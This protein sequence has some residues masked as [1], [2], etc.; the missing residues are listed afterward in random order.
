MASCRPQ[1]TSVTRGAHLG[2][3]SY[4]SRAHLVP[5]SGP[6]RTHLGPIS[7]PSRALAVQ[8]RGNDP[9]RSMGSGERFC[10]LTFTEA[11][12]PVRDGD[13][14]EKGDRRVKPRNRRQPGR[15]RL[16]WTAA[17]TTGCYGSVHP[18]LRS[19][20]STTQLPSQLL[21]RTES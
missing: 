5:I 7:C 14:W 15:P 12:R 2:P 20:H 17:R 10:C 1:M 16:P 19:D 6:C 8:Q 11:S 3:T 21:C 18:A 4:P 13:E 9:R